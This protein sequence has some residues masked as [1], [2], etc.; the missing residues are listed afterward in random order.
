MADTFS[1]VAGFRCRP[2]LC[3][4]WQSRL[5]G[6]RAGCFCLKFPRQISSEL[7]GMLF[8]QSGYLSYQQMNIVVSIKKWC[9]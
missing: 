1:A 6:L 5:A 2:R 8:Y 9:C 3:C 7:L 4:M